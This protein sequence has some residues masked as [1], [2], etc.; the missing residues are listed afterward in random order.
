M[1]KTALDLTAEERVLYQP[2]KAIE[3]RQRSE[4]EQ[5]EIRWRKAQEVARQAAR[6]LRENYGANRVI[7]FGSGTQ[8]AIFTRWSDID[9]AAWGIPPENYYAAVA[10]V[11]GL[12]A[13]IS[14]D[15]VDP[16]SCSPMLRAEIQK[17]S[18]DL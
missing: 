8:A 7:L 9:L 12:S 2:R 5:V 11:S 13:E 18:I 3:Q 4:K 14:I 6:I 16:E 1:A 17:A 15:L 10:A